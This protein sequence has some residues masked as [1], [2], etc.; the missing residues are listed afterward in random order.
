MKSE[1]L[2]LGA[3]HRGPLHPYEIKRRL[4][5]ALVECYTDVDVGTLYYAIG[6]LAKSGEIEPVRSEKVARGGERTVY[7]ITATGKARFKELLRER[8]GD[9][10][11]VA[12]TIYPALLFLHLA[13][14][15][16]L[17]DLLRGRLVET[18][19]ALEEVK[20]MKE[21]IGPPV[22]TGARY[23]IDHLIE[24]RKLD[25]RWIG[26]LLSDVEAGKLRDLPQALKKRLGLEAPRD[27]EP[28]VRRGTQRLRASRKPKSL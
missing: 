12:Q 28:A 20:K 15:P 22:G 25:R 2:I 5:N 19:A 13:D 27:N 21:Q 11:G 17:A 7:R 4:T 10:G 16:S 24:V 14:L 3:L 8:F 23:L 6:R 18:Q 26:R 1:L 9:S